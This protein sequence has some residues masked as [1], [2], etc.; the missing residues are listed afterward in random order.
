M[1]F[2]MYLGSGLCPWA[3]KWIYGGD[4]E[5]AILN[6]KSGLGTRWIPGGGSGVSVVITLGV[7][8]VK[9]RHWGVKSRYCGV[10]FGGFS[11]DAF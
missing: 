3:V 6:A 10:H 2:S 5:L 8:G 11:L 7:Q 1:V 4:P 9:S